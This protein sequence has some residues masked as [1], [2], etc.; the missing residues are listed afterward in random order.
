MIKPV[1]LDELVLIPFRFGI[2]KGI[3]PTKWLTS[4]RYDKA[5]GFG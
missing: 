3:P 2:T 1:D 4:E 5:S